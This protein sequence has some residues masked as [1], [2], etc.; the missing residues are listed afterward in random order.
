MKS[1]FLLRGALGAL[2]AF[3]LTFATQLRGAEKSDARPKIVMLISEPE[4]DT[5]KSLPEFAAK[6]LTD[7]RVA[8]VSGQ[9]PTPQ[10]ENRFDRIEEVADADVLFV[11][12]R[13]RTPPKEQ[14]DAIRRH[15]AAGKPV[16][17]IRT[18]SHSFA[19]G[20][21]QKLSDGGAV[22]PEWDAEVI[23][24]NYSNHY[25]KGPPVTVTAAKPNHPILRGVTLPT[26]SESSLY[27]SAPLRA[28]AE[29]V[30][31][32]AIPG[33]TPEP[34]A[35]TFKRKDGG[36]TFYTSLGSVADFKNPA[37]TQLLRNGVLWAATGK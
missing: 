3:T 25:T 16:V 35:W 24:G 9:G 17:G 23:G 4:Y 7:F 15:V 34:L 5:A 20:K 32:G 33:Q 10:E 22:W 28:G 27:K 31:M 26:T 12:V 6:F 13:R 2:A 18:A 36:R 8:I 29:A 1:S 37:F 14:L 30:I 21:N 11:S 19:L